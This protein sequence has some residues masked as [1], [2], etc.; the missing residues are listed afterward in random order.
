MDRYFVRGDCGRNR[1]AFL[2]H[3][4]W[5]RRWGCRLRRVLC[6]LPRWRRRAWRGGQGGLSLAGFSPGAGGGGFVGKKVPKRHYQGGDGGQ[7][8]LFVQRSD[9]PSR[10]IVV[11]RGCKDHVAPEKTH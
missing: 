7:L 2:V 11:S 6:G 4:K 8:L 10:G 5:R 1:R 9:W 3:R